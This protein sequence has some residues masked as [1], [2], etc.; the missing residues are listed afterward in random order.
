MR[1]LVVE[2]DP[3][4]SDLICEVLQTA[5][6]AV[7]PAGNGKA[8][9]ELMEVND[10]DLVVLDWGIPAP[11]GI[12]LLRGWRQQGHSLPILM[13]TGRDAIEDKAGGLDSGADDYLTKPFS[14]VEML[15]RVRSLLRRRQV[16]L[17]IVLEAGD[18]RLERSRH[19]VTVGGLPIALSPKEFAVLEYMLRRKDEVLTRTDIEEHAWD[20]ASDPMANVVDVT[21]HRLRKKID[22]GRTAK[23]IH[24]VRG[25]GY[26]LRSERA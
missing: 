11:S 18:V 9:D 22:G 4:M 14:F 17:Q 16:P 21:I 5:C 20:E 23:L 10:Y 6:Y 25:V 12:E 13:L 19:L 1:I 2:D 15:A 7:D 24:T 3:E 8:A 26:V